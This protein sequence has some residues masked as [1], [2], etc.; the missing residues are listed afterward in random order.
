MGAG[1]SWRIEFLGSS[2]DRTGSCHRW[3]GQ[4][5]WGGGRQWPRGGPSCQ[6]APEWAGSRMPVWARTSS[7]G[8]AIVPAS[9][10]CRAL[11]AG[12]RPAW[13]GRPVVP[14]GP[15][16]SWEPPITKP[17]T[18]GACLVVALVWAEGGGPQTPAG[19]AA[20]QRDRLLRHTSRGAA[21]SSV[22]SP[23]HAGLA[24]CGCRVRQAGVGRCRCPGGALG[25]EPKGEGLREPG[26]ASGAGWVRA[27]SLP[28]PPASAAAGASP[29]GRRPARRRTAVGFR[30][31]GHFAV[32]LQW[33]LPSLAE[34]G[35]RG[36]F[37]SPGVQRRR[38][39]LTPWQDLGGRHG[40]GRAAPRWVGAARPEALRGWARL[41]R[42]PLFLSRGP[43]RRTRVHEAL[44]P[45]VHRRPEAA[46]RGSWAGALCPSA[47]WAPGIHPSPVTSVPHTG[48]YSV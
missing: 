27:Q 38:R 46:G 35:V 5:S 32:S 21:V 43:H 14:A 13:S 28:R 20:G 19:A 4:R 45:T 23:W 30:P 34:G 2:R 40:A 1:A 41:A 26:S 8:V 12:P 25:L 48:R 22:R 24:R 39:S 17:G 36:L 29:P 6:V 18:R 37:M 9:C 33:I 16:L 44:P 7:L 42:G 3:E 47:R 15:R 11:H 31:N 10:P